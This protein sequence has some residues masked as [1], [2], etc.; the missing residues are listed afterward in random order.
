MFHDGEINL[1]QVC[2]FFSFFLSIY[3]T[4]CYHTTELPYLDHV[5]TTELTPSVE[6]DH[7]IWLR[8]PEIATKWPI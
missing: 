7:E 5:M 6:E 2:C 3:T 4:T 8:A 1:T